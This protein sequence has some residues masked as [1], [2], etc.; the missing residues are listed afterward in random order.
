MK[1]LIIC[2]LLLMSVSFALNCKPMNHPEWIK[3]AWV[4]EKEIEGEKIE[5]NYIFTDDNK[6][7]FVSGN[8]IRDVD[9][10]FVS[11]SIKKYILH[12]PEDKDIKFHFIKN[13]PN[14]ILMKRLDGKIEVI[15]IKL[16]RKISQ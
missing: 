11:K 4:Y 9:Y 8:D 7:Y 15:E 3:A 12:N 6:L 1:H 5:I 14:S 2:S 13:G 10:C 16:I